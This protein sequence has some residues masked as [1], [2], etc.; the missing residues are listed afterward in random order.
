MTLYATT[1]GETEISQAVTKATAATVKVDKVKKFTFK[2]TASYTIGGKDGYAVLSG[3][4]SIPES[5]LTLSFDK[6]LN[7]ADKNGQENQ[8]ATCFDLT[9]DGKLK[10]K[11]GIDAETALANKDNWTG[12]VKYTATTDKDYYDNKDQSGYAK[13]TVKV[14]D[15]AVVKYTHEP[16]ELVNKK[17]ETAA[18]QVIINTKE[19]V[20][21]NN[22]NIAVAC[23]K[24]DKEGDPFTIT[25]DNGKLKLTMTGESTKAKLTTKVWIVPADSSN[26][27]LF[28]ND[29]GSVKDVALD[30]YKQNATSLSLTVTFKEPTTVEPDPTVVDTVAGAKTE[31]DKWITAVTG[32]TE[33]PDWLTAE[34]ADKAAA[35]KAVEDA[36]AEA[37][38]TADSI[39]V[40]VLDTTENPF[41]YVAAGTED[42]SISGKIKVSNGT[43]AE[44]E[45]ISFNFTIPKKTQAPVTPQASDFEEAIKKAVSEATIEE[46]QYT[47]GEA[48]AAGT[49]DNAE[50]V[51][52]DISKAITDAGI[53]GLDAFKVELAEQF[54]IGKAPEVG[55][56]G[57]AS[58]VV[59]VTNN[60][61][62]TN[63][64]DIT[65]T[66]EIPALTE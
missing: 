23:A 39:T 66:L 16:V 64:A 21:E 13:I 53:E 47:A 18:V 34:F 59:T 65:I 11:T 31:V 58:I 27:G 24:V 36:L 33:T 38:K 17:D 61:D 6:L 37:V 42:G 57:E 52:S 26:I 63:K 8:F 22:K 40:E 12:Y 55:T 32:A 1:T 15:K 54:T 35:K 20:H 44:D 3:K 51:K 41:N 19:A 25:V 49:M 29:D 5:D 46:I 45:I 28:K 9:A 14:N 7:L 48:G 62:D 50:K 56:A 10:V 60:D 30:V 43:E 2:P 4:S